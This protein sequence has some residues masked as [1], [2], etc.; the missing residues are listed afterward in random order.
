MIVRGYEL[1]LHLFKKL[2]G[3]CEACCDLY[4]CIHDRKKLVQELLVQAFELSMSL[5]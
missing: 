4:L 2:R 3:F 1:L 5:F